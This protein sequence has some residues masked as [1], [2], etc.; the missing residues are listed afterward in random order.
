MAYRVKTLESLRQ[1][2]RTTR[3]EL[4]IEIPRQEWERMIKGL[5]VVKPKRG[6]AL[7][8][9]LLDVW[10]P[11]PNGPAMVRPSC[12]SYDPNEICGVGVGPMDPVLKATKALSVG[13][14]MCRPK[15]KKAG[16][17]TLKN[18]CALSVPTNGK[19]RLACV[20]TCSDLTKPCT[21]TV[22]QLSTKTFQIICQ[23]G[24]E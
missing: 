6:D 21:M 23:C 20:G 14:C 12:G 11:D 8:G 5:P 22:V 17:L 4:L 2:S 13:Q 10:Y 24:T 7:G 9:A 1:I 15:Q 19:G 16:R 3:S 18:T